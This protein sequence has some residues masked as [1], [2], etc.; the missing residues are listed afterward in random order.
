MEQGV[1]VVHKEKAIEKLRE[2]QN[3]RQLKRRAA[4]QEAEDVD[5]SEEFQ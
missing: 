1:A 2:K 5:S 4:V 3:K